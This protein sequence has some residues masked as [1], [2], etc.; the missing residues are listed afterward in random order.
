MVDKPKAPEEIVLI[1]TLRLNKTIYG[2]VTGLVAG[3][4]IFLVTNLLVVRG[5]DEYGNVGPHL[6]ILSQLFIGYEVTFVGS[7]IGLVYGLVL[8]FIVG[9]VVAGLYNWLVA[10]KKRRHRQSHPKTG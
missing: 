3:L 8:G 5:P 1:H 7:L 9:H 6:A 10:L 2:V 4:G